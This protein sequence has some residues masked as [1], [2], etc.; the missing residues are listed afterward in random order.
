[1][2][3]KHGFEGPQMVFAGRITALLY[4]PKD[5]CH[6]VKRGSIAGIRL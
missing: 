3:R 1:M 2:L 4:L 6:L 5:P